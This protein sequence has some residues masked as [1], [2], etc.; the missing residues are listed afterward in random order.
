M[1]LRRAAR[2]KEGCSA[3]VIDEFQKLQ[4]NVVQTTE[5]STWINRAILK[6][7]LP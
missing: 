2:V 7:Q 1:G 6:R 5:A 3:I 4:V